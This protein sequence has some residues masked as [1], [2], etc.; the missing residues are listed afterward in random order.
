MAFSFFVCRGGYLS[1]PRDGGADRVERRRSKRR[2]KL[3]GV[4]RNGVMQVTVKD[5]EFALDTRGTLQGIRSQCW[6]SSAL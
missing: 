4:E 1:P 6:K 3:D 2:T 5:V